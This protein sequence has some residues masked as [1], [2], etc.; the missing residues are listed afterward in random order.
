M[1]RDVNNS[2]I[3]DNM[4]TAIT[5]NETAPPHD[6]RYWSLPRNVR[7]I[8]LEYRSIDYKNLLVFKEELS[9]VDSLV[10]LSKS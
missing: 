3:V 5:M 6:V 7:F 4:R 1:L 9:F 10:D 8:G 2:V